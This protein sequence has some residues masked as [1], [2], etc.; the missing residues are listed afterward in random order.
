M[1]A[2][3]KTLDGAKALHAEIVQKTGL[4]LRDN[5]A[6]YQP[7]WAKAA[8]DLLTKNSDDFDYLEMVGGP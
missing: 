6:A 8:K 4:E 7:V 3:V 2:A 1:N 5:T